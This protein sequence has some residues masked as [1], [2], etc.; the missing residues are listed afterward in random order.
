MSRKRVVWVLAAVVVFSISSVGYAL[1]AYSVR[2][3]F[4]LSLPD[5]NAVSLY[6]WEQ[7]KTEEIARSFEGYNI[8][9]STGFYE[10]KPEQ[11]KIVTLVVKKEEIPKV[12]AL[13]KSYAKQFHQDSVMMVIVP[14]LEWS[15]IEAESGS[16]MND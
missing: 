2:L 12:K 13:A 11:S 15:F 9:D 14:V 6:D 8:V 16:D 3:F 7:F 5:G 1:E 4:G 10:G